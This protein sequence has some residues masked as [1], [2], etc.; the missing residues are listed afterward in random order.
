MN[1]PQNTAGLQAEMA[2]NTLREALGWGV[3]LRWLAYHLMLWLPLTMAFFAF[4]GSVGA[5]GPVAIA[6]LALSGH[7]DPARY[8]AMG[9]LSLL[10]PFALS[11]GLRQ[12]GLLARWLK[13][14]TDGL[15]TPFA[16]VREAKEA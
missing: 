9:A 1:A 13:M 7:T 2:W 16:F 14:V 8:I 10:G 3:W 5:G 15:R 12:G 11:H 4:V 6:H